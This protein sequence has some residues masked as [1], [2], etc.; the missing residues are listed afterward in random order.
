MNKKPNQQVA[1]TWNKSGSLLTLT[2]KE[3]VDCTIADGLVDSRGQLLQQLSAGDANIVMDKK[4]ANARR[5]L[6]LAQRKVDEIGKDFDLKV[7]QSKYPMTAGK[8]L[9]ILRGARTDFETLKALSKKYPDLHLDTQDIEAELNTI[10]AAYEN[11]S[12]ESKKRN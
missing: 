12:R 7:K 5:E 1:K 2:A 9:G 4:I 10:N 11:A 3:A 6:L 8:F